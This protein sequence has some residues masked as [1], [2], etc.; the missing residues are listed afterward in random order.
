MIHKKLKK[1]R[2]LLIPRLKKVHWYFPQ[3][4]YFDV[5]T[6]RGVV[7]RNPMSNE[8]FYSFRGSLANIYSFYKSR[9][10]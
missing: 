1:K 3:Y 7:L 9:G 8:I 10:S 2:R 5:K 4:F 6:L